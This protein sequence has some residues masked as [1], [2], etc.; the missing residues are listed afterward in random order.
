[1]KKVKSA[2][3]K[4]VATTRPA[5]EGTG[6]QLL[7]L[8]TSKRNTTEEYSGKTIMNIEMMQLI[9][10]RRAEGFIP[11]WQGQLNKILFHFKKTRLTSS[12]VTNVQVRLC[13]VKGLK[14]SFRTKAVHLNKTVA[15]MTDP[16]KAAKSKIN[17]Q[18]NIQIHQNNFQLHPKRKLHLQK[19]AAHV[20]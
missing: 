20:M 2:S 13:S 1:M 8:M 11:V 18:V 15:I 4:G 10:D 3:G 5:H 14:S 17:V 9:H 19:W 16:Y 12:Q 7:L 6:Q